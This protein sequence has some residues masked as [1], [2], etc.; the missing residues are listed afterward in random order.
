MIQ[1]I[2][3][4]AKCPEYGQATVPFPIR[5]GNYPRIIEML[6]ARGPLH[7]C[8]HL[9]RECNQQLRKRVYC[10]SGLLWH[11]QPYRLESGAICGDL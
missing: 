9:Y 10:H 5:E 7:R 1:V 4:N 11:S 8:G 6:Q 2:V 3:S